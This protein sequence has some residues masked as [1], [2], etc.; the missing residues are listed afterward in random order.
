MP[1]AV[2]LTGGIGSGKTT[3]A[4]AFAAL[5]AAVV[6]TDAIAHELTA[7]G[8]LAVAEIGR[9]FGRDFVTASGALD[10]DKMRQRVFSDPSAK[11]L[12]ESVLHPAIR[13]ET[14]LRIESSNVDYVIVVI[15]LL[16]ET[17]GNR[18][19]ARRVLVVDCD[20]ETQIRRVMSRSRLSRQQVLAIMATQASREERLQGAD[21][22][23]RNDNGLDAIDAQV[24]RLHDLYLALAKKA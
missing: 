1:Y 17:G 7:P 3:V 5:G 14:E 18:T 9:L 13:R 10:R 20:P 15:P 16:F 4:N 24:R 23:I 6:D 8:Q 21:D 22:V 12:L 19:K 2:S 11:R